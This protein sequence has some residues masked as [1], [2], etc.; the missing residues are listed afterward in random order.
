[1]ELTML[2]IVI[3]TAITV[4]FASWKLKVFSAGFT[5]Y[6][7]YVVVIVTIYSMYLFFLQHFA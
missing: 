4:L 6:A 2:Y 7:I 3:I 1:M 5:C